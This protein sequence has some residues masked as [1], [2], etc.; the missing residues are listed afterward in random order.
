MLSPELSTGLVVVSLLFAISSFAVSYIAMQF[1]LRNK[2][3]DHDYGQI[4]RNISLLDDNHH[5]LLDSHK[6]LR[7]RFGMRELREK[8]KVGDEPEPEVIETHVGPGKTVDVDAWKKQKR[9][10][11]AQGKLKP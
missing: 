4:L 5:A 6:R 8:R 1:A 9:I 7:S 11:L 3:D 10:E 2:R